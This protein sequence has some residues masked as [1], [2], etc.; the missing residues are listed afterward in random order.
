MKKISSNFG[1]LLIAIVIWGVVF[2][3]VIDILQAFWKIFGAVCN[4]PVLSGLAWLLEW[5]RALVPGFLF[6]IFY[7]MCRRTTVVVTKDKIYVKNVFK[8]LELSESAFCHVETSKK[9]FGY[10]IFMG[11]FI[12]RYLIFNVDGKQIKHRV[13]DMSGAQLEQI[14]DAVRKQRMLKLSIEEKMEIQDDLQEGID[15]EFYVGADD[16]YFVEKKYRLFVMKIL[17]VCGMLLVALG[18]FGDAGDSI[19]FIPSEFAG[20]IALVYAFLTPFN[21]ML[22]KIKSKQCPE[23]IKLEADAIWIKD[24]RYVYSSL[25]K[26]EL[27]SP[28]KVALNNALEKRYLWIHFNGQVKKY[29]MGSEV[30]FGGYEYFCECLEKAMFAHTDK[31]IYR[32]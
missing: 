29:W 30:S 22:L 10:D 4:A 11:Y 20:T 12:K 25:M 28:R 18:F 16:V 1:F 7:V 31:I 15:N 13:Y 2:G 23:Y 14:A 24:E 32:G 9:L 3:A 6:G 5:P 27:T 19:S 8:K 26:L 17:L 21:C